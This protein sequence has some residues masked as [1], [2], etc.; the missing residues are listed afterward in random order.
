[1]TSG[2]GRRAQARAKKNDK[3]RRYRT[4]AL[5]TRIVKAP[6]PLVNRK[7]VGGGELDRRNHYVMYRDH[8]PATSSA[9]RWVAW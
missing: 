6:P 3:T 5:P 1:M 4:S 9:C 2:V 8:G 7:V